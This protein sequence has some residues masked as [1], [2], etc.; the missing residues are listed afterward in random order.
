MKKSLLSALLLSLAAH[1]GA[2][3]TTHADFP[4]HLS[5]DIG[6]G[7]FRL[8]RNVLGKSDVTEVLPYAYFD[9][10]RFFARL[11]TFGVKT[12]KLGAG[13]LELAARVNFDGMD[14]ERGLNRRSNSIPLGIG[15]LQETRFGDF[16]LNAFYDVN[17][18][19]GSLLEAVYAA[20]FDLGRAS[21]YPQFGIERRSSSYNDYYYGVTGAESAA[22]GF[23]AYHAGATTTPMLGLTVEMPLTGNWVGNITF[24][25]KWL[26]NGIANSPIVNHSTENMGLVAINYR[27]K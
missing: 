23:R 7:V 18:S 5:G 20:Q 13:Y 1:A 12:V 19:H 27:F 14:A 24:R 4:D 21:F 15:T 11:D 10:G 22:S 9:Y 6:P 3:E 16:F 8:E 25:R 26:G 17:K 2:Q